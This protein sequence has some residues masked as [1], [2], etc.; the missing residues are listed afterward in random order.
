MIDDDVRFDIDIDDIDDG[1]ANAAT[2]QPVANN[3]KTR[4][5]IML[6]GE[7]ACKGG[8]GRSDWASWSGLTKTWGDSL[9]VRQGSNVER[10]F[11]IE[12]I[13]IDSSR[14][15]EVTTYYFN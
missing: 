5:R 6:I 12:K 7:D 3:N 1:G 13:A 10:T 9:F 2:W 15:E 8:G 4:R 11:H 14:Y